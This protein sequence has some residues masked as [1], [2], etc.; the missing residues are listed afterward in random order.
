MIN[1]AINRRYFFICLS[2]L[3]GDIFCSPC[4]DKGIPFLFAESIS[5]ILLDV[6]DSKK[7]TK[8]VLDTLRS[9]QACEAFQERQ[10][11]QRCPKMNRRRYWKMDQK[12][13]ELETPNYHASPSMY[14]LWRRAIEILRKGF[15]RAHSGRGSRS[16][17]KIRLC[18]KVPST[19]GGSTEY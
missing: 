15:A 5:F 11:E 7:L 13:C 4:S 10:L 18:S 14:G 3:F 12:C 1:N 6:L 19:D 8:N 16:E 2:F 9:H 17:I